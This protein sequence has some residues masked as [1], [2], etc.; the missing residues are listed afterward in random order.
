MTAAS[1]QRTSP[2]LLSAPV[3]PFLLAA[4][5]I[6]SLLAYDV[7]EI[8]PAAAVR[9]LLVSLAITGRGSRLPKPS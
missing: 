7:G 8:R 4:Y 9:A 6:L 2:G 3:Y 5:P 1:K